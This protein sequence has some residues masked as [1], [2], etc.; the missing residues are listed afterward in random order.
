MTFLES[1]RY[2]YSLGHEMVAVKMELESIR[3]LCHALGDPQKLCPAVHIAGTNGKGSTSAMTEAMVKASGLRVGLY[4]SPHLVN[5]TERIRVDGREISPEDFARLATRVR[6]ISEQLVTDELLTAPP[7]FFEQVTAIAFLYFVERK[8]D[9]AILEVGLGGRLD[10]TN[11][12]QPLVCAITP[13]SA[14]HQ[15]YLGHTLAAIAAEK[16]GIIKSTAPVVV[17][18][19]EPEAMKVIAEKCA[20]ARAPLI[21]AGTSDAE[22]EITN[23]DSVGMYGFHYRARLAQYDLRLNLRGRHQIIN[24]CAAIH[25]AEQLQEAGLNLSRGAIV[26]GLASV[27]W[28]GRLEL[29]S[30]RTAGALPD[31]L[32]DGAHN[33][34]GARVL[35]DFLN[36]H[37]P[38]QLTLIFGVM[39]DKALTEIAESLFPAAQ[40]IIATR[41]NNPR[42]T[43]PRAIA[44]AVAGKGWNV[45]TAENAAEALTE[46]RRITPSDGLICVCGSLYLIGEIK[47]ALSEG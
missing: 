9:L 33:P 27:D 41:I 43:D 22:M 21:N 14:D 36:E 19:Q 16:A 13:V 39:S 37:C 4:T 20:L 44:A 3:A 2:L 29:I 30:P 25:I 8:V 23:R 45:T 26:E 40:T 46:A 35:R 31:I 7:T 17:A 5:I 15:Q 34:A 24:A 6:A 32:L 10:A 28:P 1:V 47:Q 18:P 42:S 11:I 12:C 38:P